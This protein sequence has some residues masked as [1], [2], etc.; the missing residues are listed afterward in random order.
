MLWQGYALILIGAFVAATHQVILRKMLR[1]D[2]F[3]AA[4][5][6]AVRA[7]GAAASSIVIGLA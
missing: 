5:V 4:V 1:G 7:A 6:T 2:N 3:D